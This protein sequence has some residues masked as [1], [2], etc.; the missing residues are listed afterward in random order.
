MENFH[1]PH[2]FKDKFYLF[3]ALA[4]VH[5]RKRGKKKLSFSFEPNTKRALLS[6]LVFQSKHNGA[7]REKANFFISASSLAARVLFAVENTRTSLL[8]KISL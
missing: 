2:T 4:L 6:I 7:I 1:R 8:V 3:Y 5:F